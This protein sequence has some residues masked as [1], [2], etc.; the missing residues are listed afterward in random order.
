MIIMEQSARLLKRC[1]AD[2]GRNDFSK[3]IVA[4]MVLAFVLHRKDHNTEKITIQRKN[5]LL[6][7]LGL[8]YSPKVDPCVMRVSLI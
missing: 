7:C 5:A 6:G 4:H 3:L 8:A 1:L 2:S